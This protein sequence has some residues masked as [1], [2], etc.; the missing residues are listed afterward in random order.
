[1]QAR[2][3]FA[4]YNYEVLILQA[5]HIPEEVY[6]WS[7]QTRIQGIC[8]ACHRPVQNIFKLK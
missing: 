1:M 6:K 5:V 3:V 2:K 8:I 7:H 4:E